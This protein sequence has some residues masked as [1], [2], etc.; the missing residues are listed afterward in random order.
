MRYLPYVFAV[1]SLAVSVCSWFVPAFRKEYIKAKMLNCLMF[2][3][4]AVSAAAVSGFDT[5]S[6]MIIVALVMGSIGD[7]LLEINKGNSFY[8]GVVVFGIGHLLYI[9][10][11][12]VLMQ[13]DLK[14]HS[15]FIAVNAAVLAV[16]AVGTYIFNKMHFPGKTKF[17]LIYGG[18][19]MASYLT[20]LIRGYDLILS[21]NVAKGAMLIAAGTMFILSDTFLSAEKF[22]KPRLKNGDA[23]VLFLY[24]PAQ[25]LFAL[26]IMY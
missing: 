13:P 25:T 3:A 7:Y 12:G 4:T 15:V 23:F 14:K 10:N 16:L 8:Y 9:T 5:Y 21:G 22:G 6:V 11:F 20:S 1:L 18:I 2:L 19:L 24:F 17:V 26:S